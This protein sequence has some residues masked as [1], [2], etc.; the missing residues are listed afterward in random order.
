[1]FNGVR[2]G[3]KNWCHWGKIGIIFLILAGYFF[4][5]IQYNMVW[6]NYMGEMHAL[7]N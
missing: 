1:V 7:M 6:I 2:K 5:I 3:V 4:L